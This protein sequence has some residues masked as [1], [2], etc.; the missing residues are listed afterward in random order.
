MIAE[1]KKAE[2]ISLKLLCNL[3]DTPRSSYYDWRKRESEVDET[4][5]HKRLVAKEIFEESDRTYGSR[6]ISDEMK[7]RGLNVGRYQARSLMQ[8]SNLVAEM[9][10]PKHKYPKGNTESVIAPNRLNREF[11]V[12]QPNTV[13]AGDITYIYTQQGWLYLAVVLDLFSRRVVGWSFS[14]AP[15]S[16]LTTNALAM[17]LACRKPAGEVLFHSDQGCQYTSL[18]FREFCKKNG[19]LQSMSR[20]GNCWDNAVAERFF[21]SLKSE[22]VRRRAY[23]STTEAKSDVLDYI[24]RFYNHVRIHSAIGNKSPAKYERMM[25]AA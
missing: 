12:E 19:L 2:P 23:T 16:R 15:D 24:A 10:K 8:E 7:D 20:R 1:M 6:R 9:P 14:T 4:R 21:R 11:D 13:W 18:S 22:R 3:T 25:N 17:A 5:E